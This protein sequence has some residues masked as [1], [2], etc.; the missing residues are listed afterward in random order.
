MDCRGG[1]V[2]LAMI[3]LFAVG[4]TTTA[5][6]IDHYDDLP[7]KSV[8]STTLFTG[9][10]PG[11]GEFI[12][13]DFSPLSIPDDPMV[14]DEVCF[15]FT[16]TNTSTD[17]LTGVQVKTD[18]GIVLSANFLN[19]AVLLPTGVEN[20]NANTNTGSGTFV[21]T[22]SGCAILTADE[23]DFG[24]AIRPVNVMGAN[25]AGE[26]VTD[27][28]DAISCFGVTLTC[29]DY[30]ISLDAECET[31]LTPELLRINVPDSLYGN[32]R[33]R[34]EEAD[35][36]FRPT[37]LLTN[38]D[39]GTSVNV[40][41]DIPGCSNVAPCWSNANIEFKLGP[42]Q[43]C[44]DPIEVTCLENIAISD[45]IITFAC[46]NTEFIRGEVIREDI[47]R[48]DTLF[49]ESVTFAVRDDFGNISESCTQVKY[50]TQAN[51]T[52]ADIDYPV[53]MEVSCEATFFNAS[54]EV[55]PRI[56]GSPSFQGVPLYNN[57]DIV[58]LCNVFA[59]FE[60]LQDIDVRCRRTI[61]RRWIVSEWLCEGGIGRDTGFQR[62]ILRDTTPP[63]LNLGAD[64]LE[65]SASQDNCMGIFDIPVFTV[66]DNCQVDSLVEVEIRYPGGSNII[67]DDLTNILLPLGLDTVFFIARDIC[68]NESSDTMFVNVSDVIAPVAVCLREFV[69]S[70]PD[71]K[72]WVDIEGFDEGS[73]DACDLESRCVVRADH[74]DLFLSLGPNAAGY[75]VFQAFD[76]ALMAADANG[77]TCYRDYS[78]G[79]T[80][81]NDDDELLINVDDL[82]TQAILF[83][84]LDSG[85]EVPV[86]LRVE[87]AAGNRNEC[88]VMVSGQDKDAPFI[89]C[90]TEEIDVSCDFVFDPNGNLDGLF[91]TIIEGS[92]VT[93]VTGVP[94][95]FIVASSGPLV[96]GTFVDN[97]SIGR[98]MQSRTVDIDSVCQTGTIVRVFTI[99]EGGVARN[100][101]TQTINIVGD[102]NNNPLE[103][104]FFPEDVRLEALT[105]DDVENLAKTNPPV[106]RDVGCS[107]IGLGF[108]DQ[109]FVNDN[110]DV[111][112]TKIIRTWQVIDW[113]RSRGAD[114]E[115]EGQQTILVIDN[116]APEVVLNTSITVPQ[117][118]APDV[119]E[120]T[121]TATDNVV[122]NPQFLQWIVVV[123]AAGSA[124][125]LSRDTLDFTDF[126]NSTAVANLGSLPEGDYV[127]TWSVSDPCGNVDIID[128][129]L[130][131]LPQQ[132]ADNLVNV[133]GEVASAFG[134]MMDNI[135]VFLGAQPGS[136]EDAIST[137]T[138]QEGNY[139][140][141]NMEVGKSYHVDAEKDD[142]H[143]NGV[144]TLDLILIQKHVLGT[145]QIEDPYL[146]LAADVNKDLRITSLDLVDLRKLILGITD[147][148]PSKDSWT[149]VHADQDIDQGARFGLPL[150]E[151]YF[152]DNLQADIDVQ[153]I[154]IKTGDISGDAVAHSTGISSGRSLSQT[155]WNYNIKPLADGLTSIEIVAVE[156]QVIDGFQ[157]ALSWDEGQ[158]LMSIESGTIALSSDHYN[159]AL[160]GAGL[161][162]ISYASQE[163]EEISK[164][165]VLFTLI[166]E[167]SSTIDIDL[168]ERTMS[169]Q[170][171]ADD[172]PSDLIITPQESIV[173]FEQ[174]ALQQNTPNPWSENT[175]IAAD[176]PIDGEVTLRIFDLQQKVIHQESRWVEKG[177][178][179][180]RISQE[181]VSQVGLYF[182]EVEIGG[183]VA[184]HK[185]IKVN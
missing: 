28:V 185:M 59:E 92:T 85:V 164:G 120:V 180:F 155:E 168:D 175:V 99:M 83:C 132:R 117:P 56:V 12:T 78:E 26:M 91:G 118:I 154:G 158:Q 109:A 13:L 76:E 103:F 8:T 162:P 65:L 125:E 77:M 15:E 64:R 108:T 33:I 110:N 182:Y 23:I 146:M 80:M 115:L 135:D 130:T 30:N 31:L 58:Q 72:A 14:G 16:A 113:C 142:D 163:G 17:T 7:V 119:I 75:L 50:V 131:V 177:S 46:G 71:D 29:T 40:V 87:D 101:C 165:D 134:P 34:I 143:L 68:G 157:G 53:D 148:F 51:I 90:L 48:G 45:P 54:G 98:L 111:Y 73:F 112:C 10:V 11:A 107:L 105:P 124:T 159:D 67:S 133:T 104:E 97:C 2:Y 6:A 181:D 55:D 18:G 122:S 106:V 129:D 62:I 36:S 84:C 43:I 141:A 19:D 144:T 176:L 69:V 38:D 178:T 160:V 60:D 1:I 94:D 100:I 167:S 102:Q 42:S 151:S 27:C 82:C 174:I 66:T 37:A 161:L 86:K 137:A 140:F 41:V 153:F 114:I 88:H 172:T 89:T 44:T 170:V 32:L 183:H 128:Q 74:Q 47:C 152:I 61:I 96:N 126:R 79:L 63:V 57:P 9:T 139:A 169:A 39:V 150:E 25:E 4:S 149:F 179:I 184:R 70:I 127:V 49:R 5:H 95:S 52:S 22:G 116:D 136:F 173:E 166:F 121:A 93:P 20:P 147:R 3:F 24:F 171:Y 21:F 123:T 145:R 156:D 138:N 81:T 35:G